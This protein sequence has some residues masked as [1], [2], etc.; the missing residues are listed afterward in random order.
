MKR[1]YGDFVTWYSVGEDVVN[2]V[3]IFNRQWDAYT[4]T[5]DSS[6]RVCHN[7]QIHKR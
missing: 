4:I 6:E 2:S 3:L 7:T 1:L 5:V